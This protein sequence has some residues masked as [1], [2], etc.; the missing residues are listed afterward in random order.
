MTK[1]YGPEFFFVA[2]PLMLP[3]SPFAGFEKLRMFEKVSDQQNS[4]AHVRIGSAVEGY[5]ADWF[6]YISLINI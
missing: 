6:G 4:K 3:F 5:Q 2:N 1:R